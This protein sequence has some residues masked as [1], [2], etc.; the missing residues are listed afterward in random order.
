LRET[1][2]DLVARK[3]VFPKRSPGLSGFS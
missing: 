2:A 3:V 1:V